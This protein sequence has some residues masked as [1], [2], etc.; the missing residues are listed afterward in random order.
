MAKDERGALDRGQPLHCV[1]HALAQFGAEQHA[2]RPRLRSGV[3]ERAFFGIELVIA[4]IALG[5]VRLVLLAVRGQVESTVR[6]DAI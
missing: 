2:L 6:R 5:D 4:A 1:A 3:V